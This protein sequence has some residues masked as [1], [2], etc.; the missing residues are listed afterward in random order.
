MKKKLK[1]QLLYFAWSFSHQAIFYEIRVPVNEKKL[2]ILPSHLS[3]FPLRTNLLWTATCLLWLFWLTVWMATKSKF[4][5][6][7][8]LICTSFLVPFPRM[9]SFL[10]LWWM[11]F[12]LPKLIIGSIITIT[13]L[14]SLH[15]AR[16]SFSTKHNSMIIHV[17]NHSMHLISNTSHVTLQLFSPSVVCA[18][19]MPLN[20]EQ[21][22]SFQKFVFSS[23]FDFCTCT[24][25]GTISNVYFVWW[26]HWLWLNL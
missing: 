21:S 9:W 26:R 25:F 6:K 13:A 17:L 22:L 11:L 20:F 23:F 12:F 16:I 1:W 4:Y 7:I 18:I 19:D 5:C 24:W 10:F 15:C 8:F 14:C 2:T 3:I